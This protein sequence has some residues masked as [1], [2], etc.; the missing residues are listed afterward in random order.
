MKPVRLI[1]LGAIL[2]VV[3]QAAMAF[4]ETNGKAGQAGPAAAAPSVGLQSGGAEIRVPGLGAIGTLPKLDFGLE[5]LYGASDS[6]G[7]REQLN[8]NDPNDLQIR[9]TVKYKF[10]N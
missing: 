1:L 7:A 3:S 6:K 5:L 8:K 9:G 4:Q 2:G 10:N